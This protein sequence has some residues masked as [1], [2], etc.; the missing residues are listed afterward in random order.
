MNQGQ[1]TGFFCDNMLSSRFKTEGKETEDNGRFKGR[2][3]SGTKGN[4]NTHRV[5]PSAK[6][7]RILP[8]NSHNNSVSE[9]LAQSLLH[10]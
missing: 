4:N 2:E 9:I 7:T 8:F 10:R 1:V 6:S 3:T 5:S